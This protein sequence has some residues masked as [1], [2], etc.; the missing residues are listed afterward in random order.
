LRAG[1]EAGVVGGLADW[2]AVT[3]LFRHPFGLRIPH[4]A[5]IPR[6]KDRIGEGLG[7]FV[8]RHFLAPEL[9]RRR[10]RE[11]NAAARLGG[12]LRRPDNAATLAEQLIAVAPDVVRSLDD[13][14]V[15]A[16]YHTAF[17]QQL[18]RVDV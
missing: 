9:I 13:A 2:F 6:N 7:R 17:S 11:G 12:W 4:T 1:A 16:F 14:E 3:A 10:L 15:R 5:I 18:G 8:E